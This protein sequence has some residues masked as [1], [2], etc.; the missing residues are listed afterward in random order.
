MSIFT[1]SSPRAW[2]GKGATTSSA[3]HAK[4]AF[5]TVRRAKGWPQVRFVLCTIP[6]PATAPHW[7]SRRIKSNLPDLVQS[8]N[9]SSQSRP[10]LL[11]T[12]TARLPLAL[13]MGGGPRSVT[14]AA[15]ALLLL[16]RLHRAHSLLYLTHA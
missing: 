6:R 16:R 14:V 15:S 2:I 1:G 12:I 8:A 10:L 13:R 4:P 9:V 11:T 7:R 5:T 3:A